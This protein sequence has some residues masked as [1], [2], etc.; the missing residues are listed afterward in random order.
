MGSVGLV[1]EGGANRGIFTAGV[2][3]CLKRHD[4]YL[5]Y[6]ISVSVGTCNA[7]D[8]L[9]HQIGRTMSCMIPEGRNDPP[10]S[11][12]HLPTKHSMIDL[13]MVFDRYPNDLLP[14]DYEAYFASD[15][16]SEYV[17]TNCQT[18]EAEYL[19]ETHDRE[20]LMR[21]CRASCSM[22]YLCTMVTLEGKEYLDGGIADAI[23]IRRAI[24]KGYDRNI[25]VLTRERTYNSGDLKEDERNHA[26]AGRRHSSIG[27]WFAG[28]WYRRYPALVQALNSR[29]CRYRETRAL[30]WELE[31]NGRVLI[32]CPDEVLAKGLSNNEENMKNFYKEGYQ[33]AEQRISEIARFIEEE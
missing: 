5:P 16:E 1:L 3:D 24:E 8:Y 2:L 14:F 28:R 22:P 11:I 10:I 33:M 31:N 25:V 6:V 4:I 26:K 29:N 12:R 21:V 27:Q 15:I 7:I 13:D 17:V 9:S 19:T 18:G 20:R 23:P 30:L 32:F